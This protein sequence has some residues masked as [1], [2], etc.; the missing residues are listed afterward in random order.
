MRDADETRRRSAENG[1][2]G[3]KGAAGTDESTTE[4]EEK[5]AAVDEPAADKYSSLTDDVRT[6]PPPLREYGYTD[7]ISG[8]DSL[9]GPRV[10]SRQQRRR[11]RRRRLRRHT[12]IAHDSRDSKYILSII[13]ERAAAH[14]YSRGSLAIEFQRISNVFRAV[15]AYREHVPSTAWWKQYLD[16]YLDNPVGS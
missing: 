9:R 1:T 15:F 4:G 12:V 5:E 7:I 14:H 6:S 2:G 3:E 10:Y 11:R 16:R 8:I 13:I